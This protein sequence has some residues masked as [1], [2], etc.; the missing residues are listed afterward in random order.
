[1]QSTLARRCLGSIGSVGYEATVGNLAISRETRLLCQ[2]FTGK[3][4][5][6]CSL[7]CYHWAQGTFHCSQAIEYGTNVVGGVTPG[8]GGS[9]HLGLPVYNSVAEVG[10]R[11]LGC[12]ACVGGRGPA[13]HGLGHLRPAAARRHG[14]PRR[15]RGRGSPRRLHHRGHP[16]ARHGP[17]MRCAPGP[18]MHLSVCRS[19]KPCAPRHGH[20]CWAPTVPASSVRASARLAS[21]PGTSTSPAR[22]VCCLCWVVLCNL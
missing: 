7:P 2:G 12:W 13:A 19:P 18:P 15:G 11:L 8:K 20:A 10:L 3:Q 4:V 14:H 5:A 1:M 9:T 17:G 21:C 16:A 6:L 22:S